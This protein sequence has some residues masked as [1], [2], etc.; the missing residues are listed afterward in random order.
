MAHLIVTRQQRHLLFICHMAGMSAN[1]C[2]QQNSAHKQA[3]WRVQSGPHFRHTARAVDENVHRGTDGEEVFKKRY[4]LMSL[5][6]HRPVALVGLREAIQRNSGACVLHCSVA[7]AIIPIDNNNAAYL[8][9]ISQKRQETQ[10][11]R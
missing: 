1:R 2:A 6:L 5:L 7:L 4:N 11:V 3:C 8:L 10:A 9:K